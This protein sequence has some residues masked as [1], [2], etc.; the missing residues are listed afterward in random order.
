M[1]FIDQLAQVIYKEDYDIEHLTIILPSQR[2]KKYLQQALFKVYKK[3]IFSPQIITMNQWVKSLVP[4]PI[5]D[6]TRAVLKLYEIHKQID[7]EQPQSLD[8]FLSWGKTLLN[9]FDEID[10]YLID[11]KDLF[12]NLQDIKEIENW[13]FDVPSS[14]LTEGQKKFMRF[15]DLLK[16]YYEAFNQ[17][18]RAD[19]EMY[20]GAVYRYVAEN[21]QLVF[22][23]DSERQFIFAGFNALSPAET[24]IMKQ[25]R[26]MGRA[27]IIIDADTF[28]VQDNNHEAGRF[29]RDLFSELNVKGLPYIQSYIGKNP[30]EITVVNCPQSTGQVKVGATLLDQIPINEYA[31]TLLLMAD[32]SLIVPAIKNIPAKVEKANIT[33]GLPLKNTALK[34]WVDLWFMVQE[35]FIHFNNKQI[36]HKDFIRFIKHPFINSVCST[37]ERLELAQIEGKLFKQNWIFVFSSQLKVSPFLKELFHLFFLPWESYDKMAIP[38]IRKINKLIYNKLDKTETNKIN[39]SIIYHFDQAISKLIPLFDEFQED[40]ST[41]KLSTFKTLFNQHWGKENIAYYGNPLDG[42]QVMGL[43]ETRMI[44]FKNIIILGLNEGSLPPTNPIDTMIPMDLR[45]FH[46]LPTPRE[47]QGLFAH[48]FYRLLHHAQKCW[49]TYSSADRNLGG[50]DEPSRYILQLELE[51]TRRFSNITLT[52]QDYSITTHQEA[53]PEGYVPKNEALFTQ[54]DAYFEQKT[55]ASA[56]KTALNC[57]LDF[58]YKYLLGLGEEDTVEEE[59][60]SST[61]GSII[62]QTLESFFKPFTVADN[63]TPLSSLHVNLMLERLRTV[64][65]QNYGEVFPAQ[66]PEGKNYLSLEIAEHLIKR[67]L[68]KEQKQLKEQKSHYFIAGTEVF[69]EKTL[70]LSVKGHPKTIKLVGFIDRIDECNGSYT[71]FDYK[72]GKCEEKDVLIKKG[73]GESAE[74][75]EEKV[76]ILVKK[77]KHSKYLLQLMIY[78]MLFYEKYQVYPE[79]TGIISLVNIKESPF[80]LKSNITSSMEELMQLFEWALVNILGELYDKEHPLIH[81]EDSK[82]CMYCI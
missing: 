10:R 36:Y 11:A 20:V 26:T 13:S 49:I 77:L 24:K 30:L 8:E 71:I 75:D 46:Y 50:V 2:A 58:Y 65:L 38:L 62:H 78:N 37:Q 73:R 54:M 57:P 29:M 59:M 61:F 72:T 21:I 41:I 63:R 53:I 47:K 27:N 82:Y 31:E 25:L 55:S 70:Q 3:P 17:R 28:Y 52:K 19:E 81:Q 64:L 34:S 35:H 76:E 43:L 15:W 39:L 18:L 56:L 45:K 33:L 66:R 80:L 32:E 68:K 14:Q 4:L 40:L 51:L 44:D 74:T 23:E 48:H 67:Y 69:L 79:N 1:F 22:Q 12:K 16:S 5:I 9:D 7:K 60:E 6:K 42:L